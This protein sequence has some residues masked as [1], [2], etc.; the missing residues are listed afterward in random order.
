MFRASCKLDNNL[1]NSAERQSKPRIDVV[2]QATGIHGW[3]F[4]QGWIN[5]LQNKVYYIVYL[6]QLQIL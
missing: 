2:L 3:S 1:T 5:T 4:S 6:N